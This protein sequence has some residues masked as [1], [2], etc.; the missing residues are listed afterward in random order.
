MHVA[1]PRKRLQPYRLQERS[2]S[3][4]PAGRIGIFPFPDKTLALIIIPESPE[5]FPIKPDAFSV[6]M[7]QQKQIGTNH[8]QSLTPGKSDVWRIKIQQ[9]KHKEDTP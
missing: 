5:V 8:F 9:S 2:R 1:H 3:P 6:K 7:I 4:G